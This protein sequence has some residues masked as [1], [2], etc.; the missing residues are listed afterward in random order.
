MPVSE[1]VHKPVLSFNI[2][3]RLGYHLRPRMIRISPKH[4]RPAS[5]ARS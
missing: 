5:A 3:E 2:A 1:V 4:L